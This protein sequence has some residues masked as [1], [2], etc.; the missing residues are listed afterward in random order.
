[1]PQRTRLKTTYFGT[2][3]LVALL[4]GSAHAQVLGNTVTG[5]PR[6][7]GRGRFPEPR[8]GRWPSKPPNCS[9]EYRAVVR[10]T[11]SLTI[12]NDQ[13]EKVVN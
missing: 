6:S 5:R 3:A 10:E 12:Y 11:D 1:M 9:S 8:N 13:L 2:L 4:L 7:T